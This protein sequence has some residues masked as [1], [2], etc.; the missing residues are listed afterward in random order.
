MQHRIMTVTQLRRDLMDAGFKDI[1]I[2]A[3]SF[4][5]QAKDKD[6]NPVVMTLSPNSIFAFEAL[7]SASNKPMPGASSGTPGGQ[8]QPRP[9]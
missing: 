9:R 1:Q 6:G 8:Q 2:L 5:V 4:V 3:D 7:R